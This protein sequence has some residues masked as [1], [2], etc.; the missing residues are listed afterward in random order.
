[1]RRRLEVLVLLVALTLG[2]AHAGWGAAAASGGSSVQSTI[3]EA[4]L[5]ALGK[6]PPLPPLQTESWPGLPPGFSQRSSS[7]HPAGTFLSALI[8]PIAIFFVLILVGVNLYLAR[9]VAHHCQRPVR[10]VCAWSLLMPYV[11][12]LVF[13]MLPDPDESAG[14]AVASRKSAPLEEVAPAEE[15]EAGAANAAQGYANATAYFHQS[16]T[17]FNKP[18]F[19]RELMRFMRM[20]PHATEWLVIRTRQE[21]LWACRIISATQEGLKLVVA[22]NDVWDERELTYFKIVE[23][24]VIPAA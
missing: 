13:L 11:V 17:R 9:E 22:A 7:D 3:P 20:T 4:P 24:Q 5:E 19:E 18:F 2:M 1:M 10:A 6:K 12:P 23:L 16:T 21:E 14:A 15:A 8:N